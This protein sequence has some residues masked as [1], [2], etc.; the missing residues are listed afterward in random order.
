MADTLEDRAVVTTS[1]QAVHDLTTTEA[2]AALPEG[3]GEGGVMTLREH[4]LELRDRL[5]KAALGL[6]AGC[7][8]GALVGN[9]VLQYLAHATCDP[10]AADCRLIAIDPTEGI[11]T[12]FKVAL[13]VGVALSL[14]LIAFQII[15]FMAP[16]LTRQEKRMLY[17][18]LPFVALLFVA[19][20]A[21]AV[22]LVLPA[23]LTFLRGFMSDIIRNDFRAAATVSLALTVMLWMGLVF[24]MPLVMTLLARLNII[25][26]RRML[27]W[28]RYAIVLIM[29]AAAVITPTPDPVNMMIV[30]SPMFVL[31]ALGIGLAR[32]FGR[33]A[34]SA[35]PT[36]VAP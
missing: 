6:A 3:T 35:M 2:G 18:A 22:F 28:W 14:P 8:V 21:F 30:A 5:V 31:Y 10:S 15:R 11:I 27:S 16:G 33:G 19:G 12:Y 36:S 4:L 1:N 34:P 13:Y 17:T 23:M 20:S 25:H 26:W 7:V 24:E 32:V 9:Q 29:I